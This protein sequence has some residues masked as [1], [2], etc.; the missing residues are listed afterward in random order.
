M[1][2]VPVM[3]QYP[4]ADLQVI[5]EI[6]RFL[7]MTVVPSASNKGQFMAEKTEFEIFKRPWFN[8]KRVALL[9]YS[10]SEMEILLRTIEPEETLSP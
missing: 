6:E 8:C 1:V 3:M 4:R 10:M 7:K 2:G 9:V 5:S